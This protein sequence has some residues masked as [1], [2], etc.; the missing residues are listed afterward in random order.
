[1]RPLERQRE[2]TR[3]LGAYLTISSTAE[4]A[5]V[6]MEHWPIDKGDALTKA[7]ETCL[8]VLEGKEEPAAARR[9]FIEAADEA[10]VFV[11]T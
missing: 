8:A 7:Q 6:L 2:E 11:R 3:K 5:R 1:M 4:A 10:G 9:A